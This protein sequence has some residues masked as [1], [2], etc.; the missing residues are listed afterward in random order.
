MMN[1]K[2]FNTIIW[3]TC[4]FCSVLLAWPDGC[5]SGDYKCDDNAVHPGR[6]GSSHSCILLSK[7][8]LPQDFQGNQ[9]A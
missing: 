8:L 5:S 4:R 9:T 3:L 6:I 2:C 1:K 7:K